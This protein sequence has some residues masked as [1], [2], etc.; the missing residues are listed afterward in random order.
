MDYYQQALTI[1][2]EKGYQR[3]ATV[4]IREQKQIEGKLPEWLFEE[5]TSVLERLG[6]IQLEGLLISLRHN[7]VEYYSHTSSKTVDTK[8]LTQFA[9]QL[10]KRKIGW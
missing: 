9:N 8:E 10:K 5:E 3:L 7:R 6:E 1:A 4:I 2:E